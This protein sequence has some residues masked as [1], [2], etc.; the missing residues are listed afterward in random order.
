MFLF[1]LMAVHSSCGRTA[2]PGRALA[3][4]A[5]VLERMTAFVGGKFDA[6]GV[7]AVPGSQGV[8]FVDNT[9]AG[10]VFWMKLDQQGKQVGAV[11]AVELGVGIEDLEGITTDGTYFYVVSS[12]AKS[13]DNDKEGLVRFKFDAQK[14]RVEGAESITGLK[15]F[16]LEN[17]DEL[18]E[19]GDRKGKKGG[20]NIEGL[21]W[22]PK[23]GRLLLGLRSPLIDGQA[24]LVP[25][26]LRDSRGPFS[27]NNLEVDGKVIRLSLGGIGI[28]GIEHD[29]RSNLFRI[30]SGAGEDQDQTDFGLWEWNGDE[31]KPVLRETNRF[32]SDLKPEGVARATVGGRDFVIVV[33]D[34]SGYTVVE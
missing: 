19:D 26:K 7:A 34:A 1:C 23:H 31:T 16:L 6:S 18:R 22:D 11:A 30:I 28:R 2:A 20:L 12:Q 10:R 21:A 4:D 27:I 8:L 14:Q 29:G 32:D 17:V 13:K 33:F 3:P 24:L 25:I 9:Q 15:E 5:Q